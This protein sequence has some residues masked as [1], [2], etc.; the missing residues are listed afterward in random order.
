MIYEYTKT[1]LSPTPRGAI[2]GY[3]RN[4]SP[5]FVTGKLEKKNGRDASGTALQIPVEKQNISFFLKKC[6]S[7]VCAC[8][9]E[10]ETYT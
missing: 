6:K 1:H 7:S 10:G 3:V 2:S 5:L 8:V 9:K 4:Y